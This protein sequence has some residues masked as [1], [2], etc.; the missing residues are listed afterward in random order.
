VFDRGGVCWMS[1]VSPSLV[2]PVV[3]ARPRLGD[4][5]LGIH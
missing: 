2:C 1:Q 5:G 3:P 4:R